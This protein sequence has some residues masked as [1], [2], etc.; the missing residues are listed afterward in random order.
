[1]GTLTRIAVLLLTAATASA[2][3]RENITVEVVDVPV[4]VVAPDGQPVRGLTREAFTLRVDG[5]PQPIEYFDVLDFGAAQPQGTPAPTLR[6]RRLYLLIFDLTFAVP[7][8]LAIAQ[9]AA[10]KAIEQS[11]PAT[12]LFAVATYSSARGVFFVT[13]F[14]RD[15]VA[16]RRAL[17]TLRSS[18]ARD[19]LALT[20]T[21]DERNTWKDYV[22]TQSSDN[23]NRAEANA[24]LAEILK[25]GEANQG[26]LA[27]PSKRRIEEEVDG[28]A[29]AAERI[30]DLEGQKHALLFTQAF[31]AQL[32]HGL[33]RD[34]GPPNLDARLMRK[35]EEM[36]QKFRAAGVI[37]DSVDVAGL[38]HTF[39]PGETEAL[40]MLARGT[41]GQVIHNDNN[42]TS[43]IT[44]LTATQQVVY[45]LGIR[46][47]D[48]RAHTIA[49]DV[50]GLP[51]GS[52][53]YYRS[54]FGEPSKPRIDPLQLADIVLN[55][56]P[57]SGLSLAL[58]ALP[59]GGQTT[60]EIRLQRS[61][62]AA[63]IPEN[64]RYLD[65]LLYVFSNAGD[66]VASATAR[67]PFND[68]ADQKEMSLKKSLPLPAG[69]YMVKAL[70]RVGN[71]ASLGF[72]RK[73]FIVP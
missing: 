73:E 11:N 40:W 55:D 65:I 8:R 14:L 18:T 9:A 48:N 45:L 32:A 20:I 54:G 61:E 24:E 58:G 6:E 7:A 52:N 30:R 66:A 63:Q 67:I 3:V 53:L 19:A 59:S 31:D 26:N 36:Y 12:D 2:Q 10:E 33:T 44:G 60:F 25:G 38:R 5:R 71:T 21:K 27:E 56:V 35:L 42:L 41:G 22:P 15:R 68:A 57:E 49:V 23:A 39:D 46:R 28:V 51:R 17:H 37:L 4:Y 50:A 13:P 64:A 34:P 16:V 69:K 70:V 47:R 29:E 43:A 62:I 72:A 1:M